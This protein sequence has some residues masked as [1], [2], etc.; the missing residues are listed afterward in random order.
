[1]PA[2]Y[3]I[4]T[5]RRLVTTTASGV[6]TMADVLAY[7]NTLLKDPEFDPNFSQFLDFSQVSEWKLD[8]AEM[9]SMAQFTVFSPHSRRAIWAPSD[10]SFGLARMFEMLRD[11][12]GETG[13]RVFRNRDDAMAWIF[14]K[15]SAP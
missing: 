13:I 2:D 10:L 6:L 12:A 5:Q 1:M 8:A 9:H 11:F 7:G 4:D 3:T 15:N 14:L